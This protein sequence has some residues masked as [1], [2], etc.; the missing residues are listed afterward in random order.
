MGLV[1]T[2]SSPLGTS[3][4]GNSVSSS[5]GSTFRFQDIQTTIDV[6]ST[7]GLDQCLNICRQ[8]PACTAVMYQTGCNGGTRSCRFTETTGSLSVTSSSTTATA[9]CTGNTHDGSSVYVKYCMYIMIWYQIIIKQFVLALFP[10]K[11]KHWNIHF[12]KTINCAEFISWIVHSLSGP[13]STGIP[14]VSLA[15]GTPTNTGTSTGTNTGIS[16][17]IN[18]WNQYPWKACIKTT[19]ATTERKTECTGKCFVAWLYFLGN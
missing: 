6:G 19:Q 4:S 15:S 11:W 9:A 5:P 18:Q 7:F 2:S 1:T 8:I 14:T 13:G 17:G 16:T 12:L 10:L 3:A